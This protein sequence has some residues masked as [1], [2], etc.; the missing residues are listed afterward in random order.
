VFAKKEDV[1][2]TELE[3]IRKIAERLYPD[4]KP[5]W[6]IEGIILWLRHGGKCAYCGC[7]LLASRGVCY[8]F[9]E[10]DHLLPQAKSMYP[11]LK[12][13]P[14]NKVLACPHCNNIKCAYDPNAGTSIYTRDG[15]LTE[16][17]REKLIVR[18]KEYVLQKKA[19]LDASFEKER[20]LLRPFIDGDP[21]ATW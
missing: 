4:L 10:Y 7:D 16:E 11:E 14:Q 15:E 3:K 17:Q 20:G 9:F 5:G 8:H 21:T 2:L 1:E 18:A 13:H 6:T 19:L 12:N